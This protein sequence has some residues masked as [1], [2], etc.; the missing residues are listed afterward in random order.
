MLYINFI[1]KLYCD[2]CMMLYFNFIVLV[3]MFNEVLVVFC[4]FFE[5][6]WD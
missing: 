2:I 4:F 6:E 1:L 5:E 3:L